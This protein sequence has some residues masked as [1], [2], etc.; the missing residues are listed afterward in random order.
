MRSPRILVIDDEKAIRDSFS[1]HLE[2]CGYDLLTAKNG[3]EGLDIFQSEQPDLVI[4]DLRMPEVGGIQVLE[5]ISR[6]APLTPLIVA[7]GTG[8]IGDAVE[9]L[10]CGAW[11][12]LLKP[13]QDLSMLTHAVEAALEKARLKKENQAYRLRLEQLVEERTTALGQANMNLSQI[14]ARLRHIVDTTRSLSFCNEVAEFGVK[15]LDAFGEHM[16]TAGGSIYLK[17]ENGLRLIHTLDPG[18]AAEFIAFP[19]PEK[20]LFQ[21]AIAGNRPIL[22]NDIAEDET[23]DGSGWHGYTD[24][25][26]LLFPLPD[27]F[28]GVVGIISLHSK[29]TPPFLDQDREIGTILASYSSEALRAVRATAEIRENASRFRKILNTIPTGIIIVDA[30]SH[31]I[32]NANPAAAT[33]AGT[34][35]KAMVGKTCHEVICPSEEGNCPMAPDRDMDQ[36][37]RILLAADGRRVPVLKTVSR[38]TL[39]GRECFIESVIDLSD[40]I[41]AEEDKKKLERQL[42]QAQKMEALGTLAGGIAHDFN[43]ILSAVLGYSELGMQDVDDTAHPL[44]PKLK[45]IHHAGLRAKALV[46]QILSFSRMQ[47]QLQ[48]PVKVSPIV[49]EVLKLLQTSLPANIRVQSKIKADRSVMGDP[50]QIHQIIMNLCTNAYHAMLET[51]GVLSVSLEQVVIGE[52]EDTG[53]LNLE[54]GP[55]VRLMVSDTG[56]GISPA[57]LERI[58]DPYFT[59][60][61]KGKGTGL[62]LAVVHG[63]VKS[64]RGEIAVKSVVG[65][66][67]TVTVFLPVTGDD[68]SENGVDKPVIPRGSEHILLV[69]DEKD[70]VEI[71]KEMLRRLGYRV[72]AVVGSTTAL[73][74]F[75]TDPFR[76]DLVVTDYNMPGL[77][78]DK[79]ARQMLEIRPSTPIIVC[80]GFS[81]VFDPQRAQSIGIR[82]VLM[83]P[84]TMESIAHAVREVLEPQ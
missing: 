62:G 57:I 39:E 66:G 25:S 58:F 8:L 27:A 54:P 34:D 15:L 60:K 14:N 32:I 46:E 18:H 51:G 64:H 13:I 48:A 7:S 68:A 4:V 63:I 81:E 65:K 10:H 29:T 33:M 59:T 44:Y 80:T 43:N 5:T 79:M 28:G 16:L 76:F 1:A 3:R 6:Q 70:L 73:E 31:K 61:E 75:K 82:R 56:T 36:S 2:D 9:A 74:T 37:E 42:R 41:R 23:V 19:L 40:Q 24:G 26:A 77:T 72:T 69:D 52:A 83:K 11:N 17:E 21:Q 55:Y 22:K 84:L 47:E 53:A 50:T 30:E 20:S 67:T 71:G 35:P 78:G 38:T 49:K 12:Y 45:A